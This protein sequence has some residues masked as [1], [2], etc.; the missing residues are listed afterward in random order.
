MDVYD[1]LLNLC[2]LLYDI[3]MDGIECGIIYC[4][5]HLNWPIEGVRVF[6]ASAVYSHTS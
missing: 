3:I 5:S 4:N 1:K 2:V 6:M